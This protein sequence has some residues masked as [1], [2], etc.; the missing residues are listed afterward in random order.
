MS[1]TQLTLRER[2]GSRVVER[3]SLSTI[4]KVN[5]VPATV[6]D[7]QVRMLAETMRIDGGAAV[8]VRAV[9]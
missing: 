7:L 9:F 5:G 1:S 3:L 2:D 8:R 4:V 6:F